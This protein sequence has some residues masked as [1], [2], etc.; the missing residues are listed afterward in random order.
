L[1]TSKIDSAWVAIVRA[2]TCRQNAVSS[3][4][5]FGRQGWKPR[6]YGA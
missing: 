4:A 1:A 2:A 5:I 6:R 3:P